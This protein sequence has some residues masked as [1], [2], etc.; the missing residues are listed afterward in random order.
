MSY[1]TAAQ[2]AAGQTLQPTAL[3]HEAWLRLVGDGAPISWQSRGH[4]FAAAAEEVG[5]HSKGKIAETLKSGD[6]FA[7]ILGPL[8]FD[9]KGDGSCLPP[10]L[11]NFGKRLIKSSKLYWLDSG[12]AA[13]AHTA[14][15]CIY[16]EAVASV[17]YP[18]KYSTQPIMEQVDSYRAEGH[19]EHW[20]LWA[21]GTL[22]WA[23]NPAAAD[24]QAAY[25]F[26]QEYIRSGS[27]VPSSARSEAL[28]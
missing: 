19:P 7:T 3:V 4:F 6:G 22:A 14:R 24:Q 26:Q 12:L 5:P 20:G 16:E 23:N 27:F 18:E 28:K 17:A 2:E 11:E 25:S 13:H 21:C 15:D 10:Y 9:A 1:F 8:R